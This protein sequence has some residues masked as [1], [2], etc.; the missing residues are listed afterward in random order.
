MTAIASKSIAGTADT[1]R[2]LYF[3]RFGFAVV[4]ALVMFATASDLGPL[5]VTLLVLYPLCVW[6]RRYKSAHPDGWTRYV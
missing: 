6:Y 2:R 5:A 1:L 3:A 4:W